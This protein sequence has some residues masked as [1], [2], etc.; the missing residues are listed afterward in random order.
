[1]K[2]LDRLLVLVV[3]VL[4]IMILTRMGGLASK[5]TAATSVLDIP[6]FQWDSN[7]HY[8]NDTWQTTMDRF[9]NKLTDW[10]EK[11]NQWNKDVAGRMDSVEQRLAALENVKTPALKKTV[12]K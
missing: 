6:R 4:Q 1:M 11:M 5:A 2:K 7:S 12:R 8:S 9:T 3:I 10:A